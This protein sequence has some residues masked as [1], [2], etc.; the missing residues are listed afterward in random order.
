MAHESVGGQASTTDVDDDCLRWQEEIRLTEE[1]AEALKAGRTHRYHNGFRK[2][3]QFAEE[4]IDT[5]ATPSIA[6]APA[7]KSIAT[8]PTSSSRSSSHPKSQP[9][10]RGEYRVLVLLPAGAATILGVALV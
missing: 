3:V 4:P 8:A 9:C 2:H 1:E 10:I 5:R 7:G 6:A